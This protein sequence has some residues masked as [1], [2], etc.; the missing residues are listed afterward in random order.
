MAETRP[1]VRA[2]GAILLTHHT[3]AEVPQ[4]GSLWLTRA[5]ENAMLIDTKPSITIE[6][7]PKSTK[8]RL[9]WSIL[10]RDRSI[11][12]GLR[13]QPQIASHNLHGCRDW[14]GEEDFEQEMHGSPFYDYDAKTKLL[15]ALQDQ[16][17]LAVLLT[18]LV[19]LVFTPR[20][21]TIAS[22]SK[23]AFR[24][25]MCTVEDIKTSLISWEAQAQAPVILDRMAGNHDPTLTT[26]NLTFMYYHAARI[27]LA[28]F[29]AL[30]IEEHLA[31]TTDLYREAVFG[32]GKD[33][34][35]GIQGLTAVMEYFSRNGHVENIPLSVLGYVG[36]P[37]ILAAIDLKLSPSCDEMK[38]RQKRLD[39][40]SKI[41]RLSE[42]LYDVTDFVAAGTNHILQLAY[43]TTQNFFLSGEPP[44]RMICDSVEQNRIG[45][46]MNS[47]FPNST[48]IRNQTPIRAKCWLDAFLRCPRAY[49]LI[50]TSVDYSLA[51][52]RLPY[53]TSLPALVRD[54]PAMGAITQL[55]WTIDTSLGRGTSVRTTRR[56]PSPPH[57]CDGSVDSVAEVSVANTQA[58]DRK[59]VPQE[60]DVQHFP[61]PLTISRNWEQSGTSVNK[62]PQLIFG[63]KLPNR[64][65]SYEPLTSTVNLD[66]LDLDMN[67][68]SEI[69]TCYDSPIRT[70]DNL[71]SLPLDLGSEKDI[72]PGKPDQKFTDS[73][74]NTR[75]TAEGLESILCDSLLYDASRGAGYFDV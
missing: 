13:R 51:V 35:S 43:M 54:I 5:I 26:K 63:A 20:V 27:D 9:W 58:Q 16:C 66:F 48:R 2:Q 11:C 4:A 8:K 3:S 40:L 6:N 36:M 31:L 50:S 24:A 38:I 62:L 46:R 21:T 17:R 12:I 53:D 39:A 44:S 37:L 55:P 42:S 25:L 34:S 30:V 10:L 1:S 60:T 19:C 61:N 49:L 73:G 28:Q 65:Q 18:D 71:C 22:Y 72:Y 69:V 45:N 41:I 75:L 59:A 56:G 57:E 29:A 14:L 74:L 33:L 15:K 67:L 47:D 68:E 32:I 7:V 52:G 64:E 23:E 70:Y